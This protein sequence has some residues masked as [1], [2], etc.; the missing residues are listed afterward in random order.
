MEK[1]CLVI[2]KKSEN[3]IFKGMN[4]PFAIKN[5]LLKAFKYIFKH[6]RVVVVITENFAKYHRL[7]LPAL[8]WLS[9]EKK[10]PPLIMYS[11]K[12]FTFSEIIVAN[13]ANLKEV[14]SNIAN[15]LK[16]DDSLGI[17]NIFNNFLLLNT[18]EMLNQILRKKETDKKTIFNNFSELLEIALLPAG[19]A[20]GEKD[21]DKTTLYISQNSFIDIQTFKNILI[22]NNISRD[23]LDIK[24]N[25]KA[26]VYTKEYLK[27]MK[28]YFIQ[29]NELFL[30]AIFSKK[31]IKNE[32]DIESLLKIL[33]EKIE[34]LIIIS[35]NEIRE[36]QISITDYLTGIY[37]RRFFEEI[38]N[39]E[40]NISKR[41]KAPLSILMLDIDFFKNIN[42]TYGH[43][44]GDEVLVSLCKL[45]TKLLRKSDIFARIGG[46]EFGILLPYTDEKGANYLAERIRTTVENETFIIDKHKINF[47]ISIGLLTGINVER[48][49]YD[50]IFKL[51]DDA[52]YEAKRSGRNKTISKIF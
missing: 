12:N 47:T 18:F 2:C 38:L 52:L 15:Y 31:Q 10:I 16:D 14:V 13:R 28:T 46:E 23:N 42:D 21:N 4:F 45:V 49:D 51:A 26:Q 37:N 5:D 24:S 22:K 8:I 34:E 33:F 9:N 7:A 39:K 1:T 29:K 25:V 50:T 32:K 3:K 43:K 17:S 19:L 48:L 40:L 30:I 11:D 41:K 36:Y 35:N 44:V 27:G 20:I 6:P